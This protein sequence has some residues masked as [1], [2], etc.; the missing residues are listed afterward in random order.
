[1]HAPDHAANH[2]APTLYLLFA[3]YHGQDRRGTGDL[4]ATMASQRE[5]Q[6]AFRRVRMHIP[7]RDG[8]A[9]LTAVSAT[10]KVKRLG[11]F[12]QEGRVGTS[13]AAWA[14]GGPDGAVQSNERAQ[15]RRRWTR[16]RRPPL[17][18]IS[19]DRRET[20]APERDGFLEGAAVPLRPRLKRGGRRDVG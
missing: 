12:G 17:L 5:A 2:P 19:N 15:H 4:V 14:V 6:E 1:M 8:W 13:P 7:N 3:G 16:R 18:E 11:W 20:S 10:G 9:E